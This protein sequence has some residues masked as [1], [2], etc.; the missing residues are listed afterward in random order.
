MKT[1]RRNIYV[2]SLL[3]SVLLTTACHSDHDT[4]EEVPAVDILSRF[5]AKGEAYLT[6][7]IPLGSAA[8]SRTTFDDGVNGEWKVKDVYILMFAGTSESA[9]KFA[10]AYKVEMPSLSLS[11]LQQVTA[12][13]TITIHDANLNTGDKLYPFVVVN[14]NSSAITTTTFPATSVTFA[15]GGSSVTLTSG[16]STFADFADANV[17]IANYVDGNGYFLMTNATLA[18]GNTTSAAVF[19]LPEMSPNYFFPT[20]AESRGNPAAHICVERLAAKTTVEDGITNYYILGNSY[21]TFAAGDLKFA[22]DNYNTKSY[23]YRHLTAVS[24]PRF[25]ENAP[26]TPHAPLTYRT[27]WGED[28][29]Y[30]NLTTNLTNYTNVSPTWKAMGTNEYCAENTFDVEHMK[31]DCTTSVLV[32]LQLNGGN[33]FYTTSVTGSDIVFQP[34]HTEISEEGTSAE[35]SF[36]PVRHIP[37]QSA[38]ITSRSAVVT[39]DGTNTATIDDYLRTWLVEQSSA[40]RSWLR[41]YAG[42]EPKH[43]R[44]TIS[45]NAATGLA[46][47]TLSQTAQTSGSTG[48]NKFETATDAYDETGGETLKAYLQSLLNGLTLYYYQS[49]YCYYRV[50]IRHFDDTQTPWNSTAA[51][52]DNT[53]PWVYGDGT[54]TYN[55]DYLGR[56]GMVRNNWYDI[57]ITSVTH[58]GSPIIPPLTTDADDKVEQLLNATLSISGWEAHDQNL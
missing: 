2:F 1:F 29:N 43:L 56:Y 17:I 35:A 46:T 53:T 6:V 14:N 8:M 26:V 42:N 31:D 33:D 54:D 22:L 19:H 30:N 18:N 10:S 21:A 24:Y 45:P 3:L 39:Y 36:S 50:L 16:S 58:I 41:N 11:A 48:Y 49:G 5:N 23:A 32:R 57:S 55:N 27:Y 40:L 44:I 47:A 12:T 7:Q 13:V 4:L 37:R 38:A 52:E 15:N 20:E 28:I 51:M 34:P 25:V 9:A